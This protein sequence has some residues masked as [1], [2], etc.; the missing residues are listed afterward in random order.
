MNHVSPSAAAPVSLTGQLVKLIREKPVTAADLEAAALF[1][2]DAVA[3][4]LAGRNSDPGRILLK[5]WQ[6]SASSNA[7]P[8]PERLAF[9]MGALCHILETDDLHRM[10]VVHPGCVVVPAA[11]ALAARRNAGGRALLI[12]ILHGFEAA[13]RIGMAVGPAH[14]RIWHNT[15]TCGPFGAAMAASELL[16]LNNEAAVDALGNAGSQSS[17]LWQFLETGAMTKHLHAGHAAQAGIKAAELAAFG[18]TG[19]PK[20][21]EGEK[22]FFRAACPDADADAVIRDP[23]SPW[24]LVQTSI[25]PWPSC[26]HTHPTID[27]GEE[28]RARLQANGVEPGR[29]R[30]IEVATYRA[31]IDVCDRPVASSDYEAKFSLQHAVAASLLCSPVD[32]DAF[33]ASARERCAALASRV[34]VSAAEPWASAYPRAWGGR[35]RL[36]LDDGTEYVAERAHAKGDPEAPLSRDDMIAKAEMLFRHGGVTEPRRIV[37]DILAMAADGAMPELDLV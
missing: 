20:I 11:W 13:T 5:W 16:K 26:R 22:G 15:A 35:V 9:L 23:G 2:L 25:K 1:T 10:S 12:A 29:I 34:E 3:N 30:K 28:L 14:Y 27:A 7:A 24:Q 19:P 21:L 32:F 37:D 18:F 33:G 31:A 6:S 8:E 17:G 4:S 36:Q